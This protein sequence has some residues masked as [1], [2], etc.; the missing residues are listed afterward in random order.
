M[1]RI[2]FI[3][4]G[5]MGRPMS[6]NL[7]RAGHGLTVWAR[8]PEATAPLA[9]AGAQT[10]DSPREIAV[11]SDI[12]F[13]IVSDTPDVEEVIFGP[14]GIVHGARAGTVVVDMSTI[15]PS[16]TRAMAAR[17]AA[18]KIEMLDAPV[19]GGE[20]GAI[21]GAL[22]IMVGGKP[23]V[24]ER[25]KPLFQSMGRNIVHVGG[26]GAGQVAKSCNQILAS[27]T[28]EGVAEALNFAIRAGVDPAKV[29]EA[30]MGGFAYS[31]VLEFHGKRMLDG[32]F[33]P[34]FRTRLFQKDLRIVL[35]NAHEMGLALPA[36]AVVAQHFN[37]QVGAGEGD[38]DGSSLFRVIERL[39][40]EGQ[41]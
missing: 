41:D 39:S 4:Q 38:L 23:E 10:A 11:R 35:D 27:V 25:V 15:S 14:A 16:A 6:L 13:L 21:Q 12:V 40:R 28:I 18:R 32:D 31:K 34:G 5:I 33:K 22:S 7:A 37:A 36:A 3:G 19:S 29:R 20:I 2:G 24:F 30:L 1:E 8:R 26:N 9:A 17:L